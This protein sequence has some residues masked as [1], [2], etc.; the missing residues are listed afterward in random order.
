MVGA[1]PIHGLSAVFFHVLTLSAEEGFP[2]LALER[3]V[4]FSSPQLTFPEKLL[5][6]ASSLAAKEVR[7]LAREGKSLSGEAVDFFAAHKKI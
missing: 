2:E 5:A 1:R 4:L 6:V 7:W 3:A